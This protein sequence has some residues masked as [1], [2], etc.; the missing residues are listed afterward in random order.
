MG[1]DF[2]KI[3]DERGR[4]RPG[5][6]LSVQDICRNKSKGYP[7]LLP[8]SRP[9]LWRYVQAGKLAPP[10]KLGRTHAA[11]MSEDVQRLR[12]ELT[13]ELANAGDAQTAEA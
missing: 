12:D 13:G 2:D 6:F 9:T 5:F 10:I 7:G 8:I 1:I 11:Y 3:M 4:L